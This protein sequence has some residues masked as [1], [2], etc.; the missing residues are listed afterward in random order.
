MNQQIIE[1]A[2]SALTQAADL[3]KQSREAF[4]K[5][6]VQNKTNNVKLENSH[7]ENLG[8]IYASILAWGRK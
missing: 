1:K 4:P 3:E 7:P 2:A 6:I 5:P 8:E